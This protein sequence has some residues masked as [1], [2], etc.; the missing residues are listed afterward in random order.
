[1]KK[2]AIVFKIK[3]TLL[4]RDL[5]KLFSFDYW[6]KII[7]RLQTLGEIKVTLSFE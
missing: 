1:L 4:C 6:L 7:I 5:A 3:F 2:T